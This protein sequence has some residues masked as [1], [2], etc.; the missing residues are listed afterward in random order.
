M[1][2]IKIDVRKIFNVIEP[3]WIH[4]NKLE[5]WHTSNLLSKEMLKLNHATDSNEAYSS[6]IA[7][8]K[9]LKSKPYLKDYYLQLLEVLG[10]PEIE[11]ELEEN[12][13]MI[14]EIR[15]EFIS[16]Q[17]AII[18]NYERVGIRFSFYAT[19]YKI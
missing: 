19:L 17:V 18:N 1:V 12:K 10:N 2:T 15:P 5:D 13:Q 16:S 4:C 8:L 14:K 7:M 3:S 9:L 11:I 6:I